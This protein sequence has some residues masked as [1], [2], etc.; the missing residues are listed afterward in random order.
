MKTRPNRV[1]YGITAGVS[2]N[3]L[4][5]GQL[6]WMRESGWEV[7]LAVDPDPQ[8]LAAARREG[9][10]LEPLE[11]S[12]EVSLIED[13]HALFS[14]V[15]LLYR[16]RPVAV[17]VSTPKAGL[18]GGVAAALLRVPR[19]LYVIRGLRME[20]SSGLF[21]K[22]LWAMERI[23]IAVATDVVVVSRSLALETQRRRLV[24]AGDSWLVGE[25]SSNGVPADL[26]ASR[27]SQSDAISLRQQLA[28]APEDVV[29]GYV[30]RITEDKGVETLVSALEGLPEE[31]P[32]RL[33]IVG[34]VE[35][36]TLGRRINALGRRA[37]CIGWTDD[38]WSYYASMDILCL[39]TKREGFPNVVLEAAAA[40]VPTIT[41][42]ATGAVDSIIDGVT[43]LLVDVGDFAGLA[44]AI[45]RLAESPIDRRTMG[46]TARRRVSEMFRPE[47]IWSGIDSIMRGEPNRFVQRI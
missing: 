41:T 7:H 18:L 21:A 4:L 43:G 14:W 31:N 24:G 45:E 28:F 20:G 40:G 44:S 13:I 46:A 9:I 47:V 33:L 29:V 17:N 2:A 11:M 3:K 27:V 16:L 12:R 36:E 1:V 10:V 39:P 6:A 22:V 19:R 15:A 5:R 25:G 23:A 42:R 8:A 34:S 38:V 26:I 37:V 35:G 32:L 30:G